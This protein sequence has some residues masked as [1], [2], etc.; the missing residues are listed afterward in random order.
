MTQH[1]SLP[2]FWFGDQVPMLRVAWLV[3][4]NFAP[5]N[6]AAV[7]SWCWAIPS[8]EPSMAQ[9]RP[10]WKLN[11]PARKRHLPWK[12]CWRIWVQWLKK[13][14]MNWVLVPAQMMWLPML[15]KWTCFTAWTSCWSTV[16][17]FARV[18][19]LDRSSFKVEFIIWRLARWNSWANLPCN[20]PCWTAA[21]LSLLPWSQRSAVKIV[22]SM[23]SAPRRMSAW[24]RMWLWRCWRIA[25]SGTKTCYKKIQN[26]Y[27]PSKTD[28]IP[29]R[30]EG[31]VVQLGFYQR[32]SHIVLFFQEGNERFATGALTAGTTSQEMR[33]ALVK[34]NQAP[35][36]AIIGCADSR[37]PV[38][39]VFDAMPGEL[40]VLRNAGN[41][42]THAEGSMV[43]SL[44]FCTGK[45]GSRLILVLGHTN[46][47]A[48]AGATATHQAG[49]GK[50]PSCA[51]EGLL[52]GL[53]NVAQEAIDDL[54]PGVS[55]EKLVSHAVKLNVSRCCLCFSWFVS[56]FLMCLFI[57]YTFV[58][59]VCTYVYYILA[60]LLWWSFFTYVILFNPFGM[61]W[62]GLRCRSSIPWISCC[63]SASRFVIW[64]AKESWISRA[65]S[66]IWRLVPCHKHGGWYFNVV[67]RG[68][69][70]NFSKKD[71]K[72]HFDNH[73]TIVLVEE[74][75]FG[76]WLTTIK[77]PCSQK[78]EQNIIWI[79]LKTCSNCSYSWRTSLF[80]FFFL[81]LVL[82]AIWFP[83]HKF[84]QVAW[85]FWGVRP[86]SRT[87]WPPSC[88]CHPPW[89]GRLCAPRRME[90]WNPRRH[91]K[92]QRETYSKRP[93]GCL[94]T[95]LN[96]Q[97]LKERS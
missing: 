41:T 64:C 7:W 57:S 24:R 37:V 78:S 53:S 9:P 43:G 23:E 3:L 34:Y 26:I 2:R 68:D 35:H 69:V 73:A 40:F 28:T 52:Q 90:P 39:T 59:C 27:N 96:L 58:I 80:F 30:F 18:S 1:I 45:L 70:F 97:Y 79:F 72:K 55:Q 61:G 56:G 44:E 93:G 92:M 71:D 83:Y 66:T 65:A 38:D 82:I 51:L 31:S 77:E 8:V 10:F 15:S 33:K 60:F 95:F 17:A 11:S 86:D 25:L 85:S 32:P 88:P 19:E 46:C 47:G 13:Q 91:G 49:S 42:C 14:Q 63:S 48:I 94:D 74:Q 22:A 54:G 62:Y 84:P 36:S 67:E 89:P 16:R 20:G 21:V 81:G 29:W 87:C 50:A 76:T 6:W 75:P 5:A 4:W 12:V